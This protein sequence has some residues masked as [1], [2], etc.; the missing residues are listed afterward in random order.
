MRGFEYA[1]KKDPRQF[2]RGFLVVRLSR[3]SLVGT[4]A[5]IGPRG[6][7][8][9]APVGVSEAVGLVVVTADDRAVRN[10]RPADGGR[11]PSRRA[12]AEGLFGG[13]PA[14]LTQVLRLPTMSFSTTRTASEAGLPAPE[15]SPRA[16]AD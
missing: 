8:G 14:D 3:R 2:W 1:G 10:D 12:N 9:V 13:A 7:G 15:Q 5:E 16:K 6:P 4:A 11:I